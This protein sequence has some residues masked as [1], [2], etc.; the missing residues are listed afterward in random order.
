VRR[1]AQRHSGRASAARNSAGDELDQRLSGE[2][3]SRGSSA[4]GRHQRF[5]VPRRRRAA[6]ARAAPPASSRRARCSGGEG[7]QCPARAVSRRASPS[8]TTTTATPSAEER[9]QSRCAIHEHQQSCRQRE[10]RA[11][12][13]REHERRRTASVASAGA[14]RQ[15]IAAG[16]PVASLP[17]RPSA[18]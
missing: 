15:A 18:E 3:A 11:A 4:G 2:C 5:H 10:P 12:A 13:V 16:I 17:D 6:D 1:A 8:T 9:G 14:S 7:R